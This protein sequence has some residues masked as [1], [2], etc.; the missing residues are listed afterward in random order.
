[1]AESPQQAEFRVALRHWIQGHLSRTRAAWIEVPT[2]EALRRDV[3]NCRGA[4]ASQGCRNLGNHRAV[5]IDSITKVAP[6]RMC[7]RTRYFENEAQRPELEFT[8]IG[9]CGNRSP[10]GTWLF[11]KD[12][13]VTSGH[14]M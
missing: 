11:Q 9:V 5:V 7:A 6:D 2:M 10:D 4:D 12:R 14:I 3:R 13:T 1:V 8:M